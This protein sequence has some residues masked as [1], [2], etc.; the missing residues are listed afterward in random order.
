MAVP[1]V[2]R[3]EQPRAQESSA[4]QVLRRQEWGQ[5][6]VGGWA[7]GRERAARSRRKKRG[8]GQRCLGAVHLGSVGASEEPTDSQM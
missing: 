7:L 2:P 5:R 1:A 4:V 6:E 8:G 3:G